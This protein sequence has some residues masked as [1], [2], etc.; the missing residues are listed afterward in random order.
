MILSHVRRNHHSPFHPHKRAESAAIVRV[1]FLLVGVLG[2]IPVSPQLR[3]SVV[4]AT[5]DAGAR[6]VPSR[7]AHIVHL[8]RIAGLSRRTAA[9]PHL[10]VFGGAI[11]L[12]RFRIIVGQESAATS[13]VTL[14]R[15]LHLILGSMV[16][17]GSRLP[18]IIGVAAHSLKRRSR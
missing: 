1:V 14:P 17:L 6:P 4:T 18:R 15:F 7:T 2:F 8:F 13:C 11:Y 3:R 12:V 10:T 16:G 5:I 9:Q